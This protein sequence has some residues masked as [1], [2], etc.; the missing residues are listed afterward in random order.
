MNSRTLDFTENNQEAYYAPGELT[1]TVTATVNS[2]PVSISKKLTLV[3]GKKYVL[4][5][6]ANTNGTIGLTI[7]YTEMVDGEAQNVTIDAATGGEAN[8]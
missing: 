5:V 8:S 1:Y 3:E 7:N 6:K 2:K 4:N